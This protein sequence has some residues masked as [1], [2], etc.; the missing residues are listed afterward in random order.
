MGTICWHCDFDLG[1]WPIFFE[2]FNLAY[3]FWIVSAKG[4]IFHMS[5]P[6]DKTFQWFYYFLINIRAFILHMG[7]SCDKFCLLVLRYLSLWPYHLWNWP[8]SGAFVFDKHILFFNLSFLVNTPW[9]QTSTN[10]WVRNHSVVL[11]RSDRDH[12]GMQHGIS[13]KFCRV[14]CDPKLSV[15]Q[16]KGAKGILLVLLFDVRVMRSVREKDMGVNSM[17]K[18]TFKIVITIIYTGFWLTQVKF[19]NYLLSL[20][21][22]KRDSW[23]LFF[24]YCSVFDRKYVQ[25]TKIV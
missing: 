7:I 20:Q 19:K 12:Q 15:S 21:W 16:Q 4:L 8:L 6:C 10:V 5:I 23:L 18:I 1:V 17:Y 25:F 2:N 3:N 13:Y 11:L 14:I 24:R 9:Q 22:E